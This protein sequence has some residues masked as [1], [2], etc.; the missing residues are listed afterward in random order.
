MIGLTRGTRTAM[1]L[2]SLTVQGS[3]N[4]ET[5]IGT[6]FAFTLLPAL[7]RIH[8]ADE[9]RMDEALARHGRVFN[10][11][12][13]FATLAAGAVARLEADGAEPAVIGRF[14]DA[15]RGSL[16]SLGDRLVWMA[17]RPAAILLG[18]VL[19]LFGAAWWVALTAFLVVH[20]A[21]HLA[22]R[23]WGLRVGLEK[24]LQVASVVKAVPFQALA[25]HSANAG[26]L[27]AGLAVVLFLGAGP[28]DPLRIAVV[29]V[30]TGLGLL[31]GMRARPVAA[32]AVGA[33]WVL[34]LILGR[35]L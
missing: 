34:A 31:L 3:W 24:G 14:K 4:Y 33:T 11:H 27:L 13:Y 17:W 25:T 8:G 23:I 7:R 9:T 16:G 1:L 2:R 30:G 21:L 28:G 18:L 6:G 12:P 26:A 35:I 22:L 32:A 20:N 15:L 19:L 10:C 29:L 5:L